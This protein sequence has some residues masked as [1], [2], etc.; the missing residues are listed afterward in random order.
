MIRNSESFCQ[1]DLTATRSG[2][3][4]SVEGR[5]SVVLLGRL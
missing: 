3:K 1:D 2:D 5:S 4:V